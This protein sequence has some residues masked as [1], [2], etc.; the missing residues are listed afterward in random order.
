M[1]SPAL[2]E[3][4]KIAIDTVERSSTIARDVVAYGT[5]KPAMSAQISHGTALQKL[6]LFS[7]C[8]LREA[9]QT[10]SAEKQ[11]KLTALLARLKNLEKHKSRSTARNMQYWNNV[12]CSTSGA[13]GGESSSRISRQI[14]SFYSCAVVLLVCLIG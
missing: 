10:L 5:F 4:T 11:A 7:A 1:S 13:N 14:N 9:I 6:N 3:A 12:M 8:L 2:T